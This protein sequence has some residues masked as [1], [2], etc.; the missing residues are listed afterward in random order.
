MQS[1]PDKIK[2]FTN[3]EERSASMK[4]LGMKQAE[5]A[6]ILQAKP[7][8]AATLSVASLRRAMLKP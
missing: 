8:S 5:N 2:V 3:E 1:Y 7:K 6:K 4:D